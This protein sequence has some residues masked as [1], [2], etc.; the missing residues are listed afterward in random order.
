MPNDVKMFIEQ[1]RND[2]AMRE[3]LAGI[4]DADSFFA[5]AEGLA[6]QSGLTVTRE[7]L[8]AELAATMPAQ[9]GELSDGDLAAVAGG[10]LWEALKCA[11]TISGGTCSRTSSASSACYFGT[12]RA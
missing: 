6:S 10:G 12:S 4:S 3:R 11:L 2:P 1:I 7:Q 5:A 8:R 9:P